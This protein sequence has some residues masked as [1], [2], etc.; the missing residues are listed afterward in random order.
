MFLHDQ[1]PGLPFHETGPPEFPF[2][3]LDSLHFRATKELKYMRE[4]R[5]TLYDN[6]DLTK[7][8]TK[9]SIGDHKNESFDDDLK[10]RL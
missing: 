3:D 1:P 10:W 9:E 5:D 8:L 7:T 2:L 6:A 4:V